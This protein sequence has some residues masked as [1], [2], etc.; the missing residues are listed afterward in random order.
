MNKWGGEGYLVFF[1]V[2]S[3]Y[4]CEFSVD[5]GW[6]LDTTWDYLRTKLHF[7]RR[8]RLN[9]ILDSI[10][11]VG[12]SPKWFIAYDDTRIGIFIPKFKELVSESTMKKLREYEK[13]RRTD[14]G[15][16]P[17][18][19][20]VEDEEEEGDGKK[21]SRSTPI[22]ETEDDMANEQGVKELLKNFL[23]D[24]GKA[25]ALKAREGDTT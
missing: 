6:Y 9:K 2:L 15:T 1:G 25:T 20:R 22:P 21:T 19:F 14:S 11:S 16:I 23:K 17:E 4:A 13:K 7:S 12:G 5:D 24:F 8:V 18:R 3:V 10:G